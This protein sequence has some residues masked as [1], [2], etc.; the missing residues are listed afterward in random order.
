[1]ND[2]EAMP[3][4]LQS[5][6]KSDVRLIRDEDR[7]FYRRRTIFLVL[8][9]FAVIVPVRIAIDLV[10][11]QPKFAAAHF[12]KPYVIYGLVMVVLL[13][14]IAGIPAVFKRRY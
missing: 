13:I 9:Q 10:L 7:R 8:Y 6:T 4:M 5:V 1:M 3:A 11:D 14:W 2:Q 12:I